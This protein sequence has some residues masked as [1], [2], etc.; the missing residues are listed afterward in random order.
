MIVCV[1]FLTAC[2]TTHN[3]YSDPCLR[4]LKCVVK[5][6]AV[7]YL[8]PSA[9]ALNGGSGTGTRYHSPQVLTIRNTQGRTVGTIR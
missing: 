1:L 4:A 6:G 3:P 7:E 2:G 8:D 5:D 9:V